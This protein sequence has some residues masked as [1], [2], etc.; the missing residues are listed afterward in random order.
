M[1]HINKKIRLAGGMPT[2]REVS[3]AGYGGVYNRRNAN[4]QI[5]WP[6]NHPSHA[7]GDA[8]KKNKKHHAKGP[9]IIPPVYLPPQL[10]EHQY[11]AS[12]SYAETIDLIT[13]GPIEGLVNQN[14]LLLDGSSIL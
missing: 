11:G 13:D 8:P 4:E 12:H 3:K 10:G 9:E 6:P 2:R 1:K 5:P 14:G 7:V